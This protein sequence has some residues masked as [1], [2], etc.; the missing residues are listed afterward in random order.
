VWG[1]FAARL[2]SHHDSHVT[3][4]LHNGYINLRVRTID[5][6]IILNIILVR[7][8]L[9]NWASILSLTTDSLFANSLLWSDCSDAQKGVPYQ[10]AHH[11]STK[12][13]AQ[14]I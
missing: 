8:Q 7:W 4:H 9:Y 5:M 6:N 13:M 2:P 3:S 14:S 12:T 11:N 10:M 1:F